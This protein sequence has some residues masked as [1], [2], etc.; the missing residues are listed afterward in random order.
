MRA[1][2]RA[3][4]ALL[5]VVILTGC[6]DSPD[7][8]FP[9]RARIDVD[10]PELRKEKAAAG[11][12]PCEPGAASGT[13][14]LPALTLPCFGGGPDV[15]LSSLEGPLIVNIWAVSCGPCRKEMPVL[16]EFHQEYGD[17]IPIIGVDYGDPQVGAAMGLVQETGVTYPLLADPQQELLGA[18]PFPTMMRLPTLAFVR[19]DGSVKMEADYVESLDELVHKVDANLGIRL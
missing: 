14:D 16:E 8:E 9:G 13:N 2:A 10:T 5:A 6:T 17:R 12:E 7:I 4:S 19:A 15:D 1:V 11:V 18:E 3:A